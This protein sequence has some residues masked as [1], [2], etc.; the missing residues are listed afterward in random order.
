M[1]KKSK[2]EPRNL[3]VTVLAGCVAVLSLTVAIS[4]FPVTFTDISAIAY[5]AFAA[6]VAVL[7]VVT[8]AY[9]R[10]SVL[11][12]LARGLFSNIPG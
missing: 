9:G 4:I 11:K 2:P 1:I 7:A 12:E 10:V 3:G 8:A 6:V 5:F